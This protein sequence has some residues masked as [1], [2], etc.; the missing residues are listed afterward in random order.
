MSHYCWRLRSSWL[1]PVLFL[2]LVVNERLVLCL[3]DPLGE[4]DAA[5]PIVV[6]LMDFEMSLGLPVLP[7]VTFWVGLPAVYVVEHRV[8][9]HVKV[10]LKQTVD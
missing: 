8:R 7:C 10:L 2:R 3:A 1:L 9:W 6:V 4:G 5:H